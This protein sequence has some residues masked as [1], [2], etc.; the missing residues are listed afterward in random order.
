MT[1]FDLQE[2]DSVL[3]TRFAVSPLWETQA[4]VQ[5]FADERGRVYHAPWIRNV[6]SSA[7]GLDWAPLLAVLPRFGYVPDF[8]TPPPST[9]APEFASQLE[10][11][12]ATDPAQIARE[13]EWC[14]E[15]IHDEESRR[16]L[17]ALIAD[18]EHARDQLAALL[19]AAWSALVEPY[20]ARIRTLLD[21]DIAAR[22]SAL[23]RH[24]LRRVLGELDPKIRWTG[25]G[26]LIPDGDDRRVDVGA[27]G[28]LLMPSAYLWPNVAAIIEEPW[29]PTIVYPADAIADLWHE[30]SQTPEALGRLL[31]RTRAR[32]LA[33]LTQPLSTSAVAALM[34]LSP[35]GASRHLVALRDAGLATA[36]R[37]GHEVLYCRT[38][39][40]SALLI[41]AM[42]T[43]RGE[44]DLAGIPRPWLRKGS[45]APG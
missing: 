41:Q 13:I 14:R 40:G 23:A 8:L 34:K 15:G 6:R 45:S 44:A 37:H 29:Q 19:H 39:L 24:G 31:G 11:I 7:A 22:S 9:S 27:R 10:E 25:Q 18:P 35:A 32:V 16:L 1:L 2:R 30:P 33:A 3:A 42:G 36:L 4:A 5:A 26:L 38:E 20:W 21:R 17:A 43:H 28:L 12:R